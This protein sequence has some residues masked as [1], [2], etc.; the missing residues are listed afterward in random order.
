MRNLLTMDK[1]LFYLAAIAN[2]V[3]FLLL[4]MEESCR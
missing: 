1:L 4:I 2:V 3:I